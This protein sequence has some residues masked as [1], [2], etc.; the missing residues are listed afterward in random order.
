MASSEPILEVQRSESFTDDLLQSLWEMKSREEMTDFSIKINNDVI[1]C[2]SNIMAAASPYF[3]SL[4]HTPMKESQSREVE[5][6]LDTKYVPKVVEYCYTGNITIGLSEAE[7][8]QDIAEY[9]QLNALKIKI[10]QFVCEQLSAKICISWYF[11]ADKYSLDA[12]RKQSRSMMIS[13]FQNVVKHIEFHQLTLTELIDYIQQAVI[14]T[15]GDAVLD[16]CASWMTYDPEARS[17][18]F[19][20]ILKHLRLDQCSQTCMKRVRKSWHPLWLNC[21]E[22]QKVLDVKCSNIPAVPTAAASPEKLVVFLLGGFTGTGVLNRTIW[23]TDL[24]NGECEAVSKMAHFAA[25][26]YSVYCATL[27][28]PFIIGGSRAKRDEKYATTTDCSLLMIPDMQC[29]Q[30]PKLGYPISSS[31]NAVCIKNSMYVFGDESDDKC[32]SRLDLNRKTW[33]SCPDMPMKNAYPIL[34]AIQEKVYMI[35]HTYEY[36]EKFRTTTEVPK[37]CFDTSTHSWSELNPLY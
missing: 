26:Y 32:A 16:S 18:S 12:L 24:A 4:L 8:C 29:E 27:K 31:A 2:H 3:Q 35:F 34:A 9:F 11:L 7:M 30:W 36:N 5:L 19:L 21:A 13:D 28:G 33:S 37:Y 1:Q 15:D 10:E 17:E 14:I 6:A 20:N 22:I 23:K 25:K